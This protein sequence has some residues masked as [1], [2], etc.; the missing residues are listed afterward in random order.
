MSPV[1]VNGHV[2][3]GKRGLDNLVG[4][5]KILLLLGYNCLSQWYTGICFWVLE[6]DDVGV[7]ETDGPVTGVL[8]ED[9]LDQVNDGGD[10]TCIKQ[11]LMKQVWA[12]CMLSTVTRSSVKSVHCPAAAWGLA[13]GR[14][15]PCRPAAWGCKKNQDVG[16]Q[17]VPFKVD[18]K[19][20]GP[21]LFVGKQ[22]QYNSTA[23]SEFLIEYAIYHVT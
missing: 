17:H 1:W 4:G 13:P 23:L 6:K 3:V 11:V 22:V 21:L 5:V 7:I 16:R 18:V 19:Q 9:I 20:A 10:E 14:T 8:V 15:F 12:A 2:A